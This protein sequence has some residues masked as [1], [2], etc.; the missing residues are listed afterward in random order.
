MCTL[1]CDDDVVDVVVVVVG[2]KFVGTTPT[3]ESGREKLP[4]RDSRRTPS[5][6]SY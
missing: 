5:L 4:Q 1:L 3:V 6:G 2:A